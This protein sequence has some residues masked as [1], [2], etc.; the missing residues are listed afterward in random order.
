MKK[1]RMS[2]AA[3]LV[4]AAVLAVSGPAA[5]SA[6]SE[7]ETAEA[8]QNEAQ[9]ALQTAADDLYD[10]L[11]A[12]SPV[13]L[14]YEEANPENPVLADEP[15]GGFS[16]ELTEEQ[17][18]LDKVSAELEGIDTSQ[19]TEHQVQVYDMI[20]EFID[21]EN[22]LLALPDYEN[23]L[24]PMSGIMGSLDTTITEYYLLNET[25]VQNYIKILED[26]PRFL[27]EILKE[28]DYQAELGYGPTQYAVDALLEDKDSKVTLE[29][30]PY[31]AAFTSNLEECDLTEEQ[32]T[33]YT[34]QVTD[35][36]ENEVIP[37]FE[38]F[39]DELSQKE[40]TDSKPLCSYDQGKE[41]YALL[42]KSYT[43]TD[44]DPDE[45]YNYL[46]GKVDEEIIELQQLYMTDYEAVQA[47]DSYDLDIS[48]ADETLS[49]LRSYTE[50]YLPA[51]GHTDYTVSYLP[52][53]L[54]VENQMAYYL[55][56]PMDDLD[57]N[58]IRVN[59]DEVSPD[60]SVTM[61]TTLA[62]E[63][64]PGH[65]YQIQYVNQNIREYKVE[66]LISSTGTTEGWA[67]YV[68][69]VALSWTNMPENTQKA[70]AINNSL[71][72][73]LSAM[74][75]IG[76][77]YYGWDVNDMKDFLSNYYDIGTS[78]LTDWYESTMND[79]AVYL[80]YAVGYYQTADM[81]DMISGSSSDQYEAMAAYLN[82]S[83]LTFR[84]MEKYINIENIADS[85]KS[86]SSRAS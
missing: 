64:F 58:V 55:S 73:A 72:M 80:P 77:N 20:L 13:N 48:D 24:G 67:F 51:I 42:A 75:D 30:H 1:H 74:V 66:D 3:V 31:L 2:A 17:E 34:A 35:I 78:D 70:W 15:L 29:N 59:G 46:S 56:P 8:D 11:M 18:L 63:G 86:D 38:S 4:M 12:I 33:D 25:D 10:G 44:M 52:D 76:V 40:T 62:H 26:V 14:H 84:E 65:L 16:E 22:T 21:E 53:A 9:Q 39:Y 19:L 57:R 81:I 23:T 45:I 5:A 61:W 83:S 28:V 32:K 54:K 85:G 43:G 49:E 37:G 36:I 47:V 60:D 68:E 82:Y 7:T 71:G 6:E 27:Q 41:Y 69:E 79:P 50:E